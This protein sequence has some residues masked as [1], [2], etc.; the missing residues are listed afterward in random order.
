MTL[1]KIAPLFILYVSA[2]T[3]LGQS[4]LQIQNIENLIT[5][6]NDTIKDCKIGYRTFGN[7]NEDKSNFVF[8]PTLH[9]GTSEDNLD[10]SE[11]IMGINGKYVI[12]VD[13]LGNGISY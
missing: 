3:A 9:L 1:K 12:V 5:T 13:A 4:E 11:S 6:A 7:L 2:M 10:Y 8:M